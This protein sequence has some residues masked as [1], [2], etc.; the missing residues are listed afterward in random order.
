MDYGNLSLAE[1]SCKVICIAPEMQQCPSL[2]RKKRCVL[3]DENP[4]E[5]SH[6]FAGL[7]ESAKLR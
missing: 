1:A 3:R 2:P 4:E 7:W 6:S 5:A